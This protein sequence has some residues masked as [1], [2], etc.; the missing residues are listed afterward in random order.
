MYSNAY[1]WAKV[2]A[3]LDE[4]MTPGIVSTFFDQSYI[5]EK[6]E[7]KITVYAPS[8]FCKDFIERRCL[9]Y[10]RDA[11]RELTDQDF[12][13]GVICD[14][15]LAEFQKSK[16]RAGMPRFNPQFTFDS[17]VVG[18]SN[19]FAY[20]AA[21]AVT[22]KPAM[23]YNPLFI[24]GPSGL[25]KTHLL[26]AI[27]NRIQEKFPDF[28]IVYISS[29]QF[30]NELIIALREHRNVEFRKKYRN[31]DLLLM[32]DIQFIGGKASTEEEFFHTFNE[33]FEGRKQ[34]VVTSD[35]PPNEI[36]LLADRLRTR[37]EGGLICDIIP[38]DYE[39]RMAIIQN[40]ANSLGIDLPD[41]ICNY[42]A[43]NITNNV[44]SL[45]G[46]VNII[47]AYHEL[48]GM[49]LDLPN[50]S[51]AIKDMYMD[52]SHN[53]PTPALIIGEVSRFYS[54]EEN[55]LRGRLKSNNIV[56][57]RQI[58]MYL[59]RELTHQSYKNIGREFGRDHTTVISSLQKVEALIAKGDKETLDNL[60]DI[61]AN[62]NSKL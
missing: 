15:E 49:P 8:E 39:T 22:D 53:L 42:I 57:P 5:L 31:A 33:L 4:R 14:E 51:R 40:K 34:I 23:A 60:R 36:S 43:E 45:E 1:I 61:T 59:I 10:I 48:N 41:E 21:L 19:R 52:S 30:T 16:E 3:Y 37:F 11:V 17:F 62:I 13:I 54:V 2:I 47:K 24:Y 20:N 6:T 12:E 46:T 26:Y 44:R 38:P 58:A 25:G 55:L 56:M 9:G 29:E 7:Q 32:D 27:A 50:V 35:R 28:N 18:P